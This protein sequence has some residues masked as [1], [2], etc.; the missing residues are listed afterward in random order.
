MACERADREYRREK[1]GCR[2]DHKNG[3]WQSVDIAH[4]YV[5]WRQLFRE[6]LVEVVGS[7]E[8]YDEQR[9]SQRSRE[10]DL[11][12][13][14][15]D[16]PVERANQTHDVLVRGTARADDPRRLKR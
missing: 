9:K 3:I 7:V 5:A 2:K 11:E 15:E 4:R 10:E 1:H 13:L 6:I 12:P 16:V 8:K 14:G